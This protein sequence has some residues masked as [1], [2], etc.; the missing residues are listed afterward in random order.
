M[1]GPT[2]AEV[3]T[4]A[5]LSERHAEDIRR[6]EQI[7][8][9]GRPL[10]RPLRRRLERAGIRLHLLPVGKPFRMDDVEIGGHR[11]LRVRRPR[12]KS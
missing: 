6:G 8:R 3:A 11:A 10:P 4:M 2:A 5:S 7:L 1:T 12:G 9:S